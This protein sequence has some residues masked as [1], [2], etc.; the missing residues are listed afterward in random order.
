M[1]SAAINA[2]MWMVWRRQ[3]GCMEPTARLM[4]RRV[5]PCVRRRRPYAQVDDAA[6]QAIPYPPSARMLATGAATCSRFGHGIHRLGLPVLERRPGRREGRPPHL[7][8]SATTTTTTSNPAIT[9]SSREAA[10]HQ[11]APQPPSAAASRSAASRRGRGYGRR[12]RRHLQAASMRRRRRGTLMARRGALPSFES[13]RCTHPP[14]LL[15]PTFIV[16][17]AALGPQMP[18]ESSEQPLSTGML[19]M[20]DAAVGQRNGGAFLPFAKAAAE[21]AALLELALTPTEEDK[22]EVD[23]NPYLHAAG[24]NGVLAARRNVQNGGEAGVERTGQATTNA[25]E[26]LDEML[27]RF[28]LVFIYRVTNSLLTHGYITYGSTQQ[29]IH[30]FLVTYLPCYKLMN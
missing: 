18:K 28:G 2:I 17:A 7:P 25:Q 4:R 13:P 19:G 10:P 11:L 27:L 9:A 16:M 29:L 26:L 6:A 20:L 15:F 30:C 22:A 21:G 5:R 3:W 8:I 24:T 12:R 23:G 14:P 1:V